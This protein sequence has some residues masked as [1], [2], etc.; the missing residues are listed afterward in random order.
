MPNVSINPATENSEALAELTDNAEP[1][2]VVVKQLS[3]TFRIDDGVDIASAIDS[4]RQVGQITS[5]NYSEYRQLA[6]RGGPFDVD[7]PY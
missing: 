1:E 5:L 2:T 4:L 3:A 6:S 7:Y